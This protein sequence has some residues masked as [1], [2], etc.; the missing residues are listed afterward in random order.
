MNS[1]KTLVAI[2]VAGLLLFGM[3]S[4]SLAQD[5]KKGPDD[6]GM[7]LEQHKAN[8]IS[9]IDARIKMLQ[10]DR[11]CVSAAK[12]REDMKK[13]RQAEQAA[14]Q[15]MKETMHEHRKGMAPQSPK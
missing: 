4:L 11:A 12:T 7:T 10:D 5:A 14:R 1:L 6:S 9:G 13:C 8:I 3:A 2:V 15:Q